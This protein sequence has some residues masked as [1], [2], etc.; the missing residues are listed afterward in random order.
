MM[1]GWISDK[2][3]PPA[4]AVCMAFSVRHPDYGVQTSLLP[5][6]LAHSVEFLTFGFPRDFEA[7]SIRKAI[8]ARRCNMSSSARS[9]APSLPCQ[10]LE[11]SLRKHGRLGPFGSLR[12][13]L[14]RKDLRIGEAR[15]PKPLRFF[16][17]QSY[18]LWY[19][20]SLDFRWA[21]S[22]PLW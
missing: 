14:L 1:L 5:F 2:P 21:P 13:A 11:Q 6:N 17:L 12:I 19:K 8:A 10:N 22:A 9:Q 3:I 15:L 18:N 16:R 20:P 4:P 7:C